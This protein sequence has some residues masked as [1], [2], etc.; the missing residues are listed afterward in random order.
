MTFGK[1]KKL[2]ENTLHSVRVYEIAAFFACFTVVTVF[3]T[4]LHTKHLLSP[5]W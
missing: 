5:G 3:R 2:V 1:S 4:K